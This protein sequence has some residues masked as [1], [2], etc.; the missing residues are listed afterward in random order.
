M[1]EVISKLEAIVGEKRLLR[2]ESL[3]SHTVQKLQVLAELYLEIDKLE[4][5]IRV[6]RIARESHVPLY[7]LGGGARIKVEKDIVGLVIKNA[8]RKFDKVGV[9]GILRQQEPAM[10]QVLVYAESGVI[11]NQ[12]VR[13]TIEEGLEGLEYQLG[14]PGTVGGAISTNAKY[15]PKYLLLN[16]ALQSV[17]IIGKDGEI[18]T[19]SNELPH[20]VYTD[21]IWEET[22]DIILSAVFRLTPQEKKELWKRGEEAVTWREAHAQKNEHASLL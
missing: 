12:L 21:E 17:T 10:D 7:L 11:V 9:K 14:L 16:K 15:K 20:F 4:T 3:A 5:L 18:Q 6:I 13:Y 2:S 1:S 8:C 22:E 19:F